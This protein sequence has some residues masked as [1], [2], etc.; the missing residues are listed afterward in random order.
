MLCD[1]IQQKMSY[2][3]E[4]YKN[5]CPRLHD[6]MFRFRIKKAKVKCTKPKLFQLL[7][8]ECIRLKTLLWKYKNQIEKQAM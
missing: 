7:E 1:I 2:N 3:K 8:C 5:A 4:Y 6:K